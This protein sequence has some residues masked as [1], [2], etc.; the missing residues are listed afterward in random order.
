MT[1]MTTQVFFEL[2]RVENAVVIPITALGKRLAD[3][4]ND[5]GDAYNIK[6][7]KNDKI[8][9][10]IVHIGLMNRNVAEVKEG[11]NDGDEVVITVKKPSPK[12]GKISMPP[13]L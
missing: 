5:K 4:D 13:R 2:G 3:N 6:I 1:G 8:T 10:Q 11:I 7:R 12:T 9:E